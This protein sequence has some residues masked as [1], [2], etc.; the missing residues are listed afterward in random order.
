MHFSTILATT[1]ILATT[2]LAGYDVANCGNA[3]HTHHAATTAACN[4][5]NG[6]L[7]DRTGLTRCT[8]DESKYGAFGDACKQNGVN[9]A[10]K[11][12]G[13]FDHFT[14]TRLAGCT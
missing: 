5:V 11:R 7:C 3:V 2:A 12:P 4:A 14:A 6:D 10:Y 9:E 1:L 8:V 13:S